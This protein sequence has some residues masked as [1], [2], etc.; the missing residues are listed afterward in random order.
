[1]TAMVVDVTAHID[2][3]AQAAPDT[4]ERVVKSLQ[5]SVDEHWPR[6]ADTSIDVLSGDQRTELV[7][8]LWDDLQ[9]P[10]NK[11]ESGLSYSYFQL[12]LP[13]EPDILLCVWIGRYPSGKLGLI[14]GFATQRPMRTRGDE[15]EEHV[16]A[17]W[18]SELS[19]W[20]K[21]MLMPGMFM[22]A[23][24]IQNFS[25]EAH[26]QWREAYEQLDIAPS[27]WK[28]HENLLRPI[29][30]NLL[31]ALPLEMSTTLA[32]QME[33]AV[34]D[35]SE[36]IPPLVQA[37]E[38]AVAE[39]WKE[40][41][42][43]PRNRWPDFRRQFS[44][45]VTERII[46][47]LDDPEEMNDSR[48]YATLDFCFSPNCAREITIDLYREKV[49]PILLRM[50]LDGGAMNEVEGTTAQRRMIE[51][52]RPSWRGATEFHPF[53]MPQAGDMPEDELRQWYEEYERLGR[54]L[55]L[56]PQHRRC[57]MHIAEGIM[58]AVV[59]KKAEIDP[60]LMHE[61]LPLNN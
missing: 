4:I 44:T 38:K 52:W 51:N 56:W 59:V 19:Q 7:A 26:R 39:N 50:S 57:F 45:L 46:A 49:G 15:S 5:S 20:G 12:R 35:V 55:S 22:N 60:R 41:A 13:N 3:E 2:Y 1:M 61:K 9:K 32:V 37:V 33:F 21:L 58:K 14:L 31:K 48:W 28:A 34:A 42:S 25:K 30:E 29:V 6:D 18:L 27:L 43:E 8:R 23:S 53:T 11:G 54:A 47:E 36:I 16:E 40:L 24:R 10:E 17:G